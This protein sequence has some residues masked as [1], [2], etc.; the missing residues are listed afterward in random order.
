MNWL[1]LKTNIATPEQVQSLDLLLSSFTDITNWT[2]DLE[3]CDHV[4]R[5]APT[6]FYKERE[7][8]GLLQ[9]HGFQA[10]VLMG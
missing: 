7:V 9:K 6:F 8:V 10:E 2:I 5:A 4:L 1:I 3:D